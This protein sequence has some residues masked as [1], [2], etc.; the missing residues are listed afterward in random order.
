M[1]NPLLCMSIKKKNSTLQCTH[2]KLFNSEYCGIHKRAKIITRFDQ[3]SLESQLLPQQPLE[4][5]QKIKIIDSSVSID[6]ISPLV[7]KSEYNAKDIL[8]CKKIDQLKLSLLKQTIK[9]YNIQGTFGKNKRELFSVLHQ[10]YH[11]ITIY[12]ERIFY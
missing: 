2:R 8:G 7:T 10:P 12:D 6:N 1:I 3:F 9:H 4:L 11:I 5:S